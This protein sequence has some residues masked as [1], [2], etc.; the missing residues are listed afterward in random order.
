MRVERERVVAFLFLA[1]VTTGLHDRN[2]ATRQCDGRKWPLTFDNQYQFPSTAHHP[3]VYSPALPI[4]LIPRRTRPLISSNSSRITIIGSPCAW[5]LRRYHDAQ[6]R[7]AL[8]SK[9]RHDAPT[10]PLTCTSGLAHF[11]S[12]PYTS[13]CTRRTQKRPFLARFLL[14]VQ[15]FL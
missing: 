13:Y 7:G 4:E 12:H 10:R 3:R 2:E 8:A 5:P 14:V 1:C 15:F 9:G 6:K 11:P